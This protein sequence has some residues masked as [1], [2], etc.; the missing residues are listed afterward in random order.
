MNL[1]K[2]K[3]ELHIGQPGPTRFA[4]A[5]DEG[6]LV[7]Q[8]LADLDAAVLGRKMESA[9]TF[10]VKNVHS[11]VVIKKDLEKKSFHLNLFSSSKSTGGL[12]EFSSKK[13][14]EKEEPY[15]T[16]SYI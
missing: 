13:P 12:S 15:L 16:L 7:E 5:V 8:R 11:A 3:T 10:E 2:D 4:F 1:I 14:T 6:V 9:P